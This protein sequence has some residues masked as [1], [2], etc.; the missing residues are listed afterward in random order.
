MNK[1]ITV[2]IVGVALTGCANY[3]TKQDVAGQLNEVR[4]IAL[5]AN[6]KANKAIALG[7]DNQTKLDNLAELAATCC[8]DNRSRIDALFEKAMRK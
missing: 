3:A 4:S 8:A 7:R 5:D 2:M 1:M 6:Y